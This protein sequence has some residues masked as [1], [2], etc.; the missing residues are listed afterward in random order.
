[1]I[2]INKPGHYK[3]NLNYTFLNF[4]HRIKNKHADDLRIFFQNN[5]FEINS[6]VKEPLYESCPLE[7]SKENDELY[8]LK[9]IEESLDNIELNNVYKVSI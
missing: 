7:N 5:I 9:M 8:K 3:E 1:M 4:I 6:A 2:L